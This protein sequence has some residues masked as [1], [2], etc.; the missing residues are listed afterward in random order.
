MAM[1]EFPSMFPNEK[2]KGK[3]PRKMVDSGAAHRV[4]Q[5]GAGK[6]PVPIRGRGRYPQDRRGLVVRQT[7]EEAQLHQLRFSRIQ[8]RQARQRLVECQQLIVRSRSSHVVEFEAL[9]VAAVLLALLATCLVDADVSHGGGG[10]GEKVPAVV[11]AAL[12]PL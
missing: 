8:G 9:D 2:R 12:I 11:V 6:G 5:P 7:P 3:A 10:R 1:L 4:A